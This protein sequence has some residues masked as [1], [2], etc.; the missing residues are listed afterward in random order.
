M[1]SSTQHEISSQI[2]CERIQALQ[3]NQGACCVVIVI[4]QQE[5]S[6]VATLAVM[7]PLFCRGLIGG[8][9]YPAKRG[10]ISPSKKNL[11]N[12]GNEDQRPA[13][14]PSKAETLASYDCT[15]EEI[16]QALG[17]PVFT[18]ERRR[19]VQPGVAEPS[20]AR[21]FLRK[22]YRFPRCKAVD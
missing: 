13:L 4:S 21:T 7:L 8:P 5:P 11:S 12:K 9:F 19:K 14:D 15:L 2:A 16:A 22:A 20:R 1:M 3:R 17:V 10:R 6:S 18:L